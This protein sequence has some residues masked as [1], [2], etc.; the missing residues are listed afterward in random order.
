MSMGRME[1]EGAPGTYVSGARARWLLQARRAQ[2]AGPGRLR[3]LA[4]ASGAGAG[5]AAEPLGAAW[6]AYSSAGARNCSGRRW[7]DGYR[8][9]GG[10]VNRGR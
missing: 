2:I 3:L 1:V 5:A 7:L 9:N 4:P 6:S 10:A 8:M